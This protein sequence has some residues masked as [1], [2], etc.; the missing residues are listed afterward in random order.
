MGKR[1]LLTG[2]TGFV[3]GRLYPALV[4]A[5]HEVRCGT[6]NP[7]RAARRDPTRQ[8]V[9]LDLHRPELVQAAVEG[10]EV[11]YYL[12]HSMAEGHGYAQRELESARGVMAAAEQAGVERIIYLGGVAPAGSPSEHL[13][14]RLETG[15][16][17]RS[18]A[19][20]CIE[21]RAG[22]IIGAGSASWTI[23]RDLAARLPFM[24]LPRW[25][26]TRSQP[27]SV[28]DIVAALA[29]AATVEC[30]E[31]AVYDLPGPEV[32]AAKEILMRIAALRG[33]E[34]LTINVPLLSPKL[35]SYWLKLISGADFSIA[36]ELVEGLKSDLIATE[37]PFWEQLEGHQLVPFDEAARRALA[38]QGPGSLRSRALEAVT[39]WLSRRRKTAESP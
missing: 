31:S 5:G 2:A 32:L 3:G 1:I 11:V 15:R 20:P 38:E 16:L 14:S 21:L 6:R 24:I 35:S 23:C 26:E 28:E 27:A 36:R 10:I 34:P 12:V 37:T 13:S 30:T 7:Q 19:V 9:E 8:W 39:R 18:G 29:G 17:L 33:T 22:M 4:E 25:L